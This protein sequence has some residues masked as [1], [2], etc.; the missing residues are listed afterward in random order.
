[1]DNLEV[2][3]ETSISQIKEQILAARQNDLEEEK[4]LCLSLLDN[5]D[6][7][8]HTYAFAYTFL[9]DYYMAKQDNENCM[10]YLYMAKTLSEKNNYEDLLI[11]I[12]H[13]YGMIHLN[14]SD[15]QTS[16]DY[17]FK[18]LTLAKKAN[19]ATFTAAIYNNI[20][21]IFEN[22]ADLEEALVYYKKSLET[23]QTQNNNL[24]YA[25]KAITLTNLCNISYQ[26][27]KYEEL[28][29]YFKK[30]KEI[31]ESEFNDT[32]TFF[33]YF[34]KFLYLTSI[35]QNNEALDELDTLM[36]M[37]SKMEDRLS[38][39]QLFVYIGDI[40]IEMNEKARAQHVLDIIQQSDPANEAMN[41]L[42]IIEMKIRFCEQFNLEYD[43]NNAY[44]EY[45][46]ANLA[47]INIIKKNSS[48]GL[49]A[50]ISLHQSNDERLQ[51]QHQNRQLEQ[52]MNIDELTNLL[53]R[54]FF[55]H[56]LIR[57]CSENKD[58]PLGL[59]MIDIDCFKEYNDFYGHIEG[60][61]ILYEVGDTLNK[62][63]RDNYHICRFGGD[64]FACI[65]E[66]CDSSDIEEYLTQVYND[67]YQKK[68]KHCKSYVAPYVTIS[69][70]FI[71]CSECPDI[72][73]LVRC[74]D[75]ELYNAK[76]RGRNCWSKNPQSV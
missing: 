30:F 63:K 51:I 20:A 75:E 71:M 23:L 64:E 10:Y 46:L 73:F 21:N 58:H 45:Y 8:Y 69:T 17:Y 3:M 14:Y 40:L 15:Y 57:Q 50:K 33:Y 18:A 41:T 37:Q 16:V 27:S 42:R 67:L 38:V 59:A 68:L 52:L 29:T 11:R 65:F 61:K 47:S 7:D 34:N 32:M 6:A 24:S 60:D 12:Y 43:L 66:Y 28:I 72:E 1:M 49:K 25:S 54:R 44:K 2:H 48:D 35:H 56:Y 55:D 39:Y 26:C 5:N 70:G 19:H 74:A 76:R 31:P 4:H 13:Y 36:E 22:A 9:A 62:F 53:N